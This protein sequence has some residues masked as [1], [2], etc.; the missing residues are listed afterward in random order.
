[1]SNTDLLPSCPLILNDEDQ[2]YMLAFVKMYQLYYSL[3]SAELAYN[4]LHENHYVKLEEGDKVSYYSWLEFLLFEVLDLIN[5]VHTETVGTY[6]KVVSVDDI[7]KKIDFEMLWE[8]LDDWA[9]DLSI[10]Y[11]DE[12]DT[13]NV[14][15]IY[16]FYKATEHYTTVHKKMPGK[17]PLEFKDL[18]VRTDEYM[19]AFVNENSG[20][21]FSENEIDTGV[22]AN[23]IIIPTLPVSVTPQNLSDVLAEVEEA[24]IVEEEEK[25][26]ITVNLRK[27]KFVEHGIHK[28]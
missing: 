24:E 21:S 15:Y 16:K 6:T 22:P 14:D 11:F 8:Q 4:I 2:R 19:A 18:C 13:G 7:F 23:T 5:G 26:A 1:M 27:T 10:D 9:Q 20:E 3:D 25:E 17:H 28:G 12:D